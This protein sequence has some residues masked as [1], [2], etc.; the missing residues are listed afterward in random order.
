MLSSLKG[1]CTVYQIVPQAA[2]LNRAVGAS[3]C[4]L[5][6]DGEVFQG[7][8]S[9]ERVECCHMVRR[10]STG[11]AQAMRAEVA[12]CTAAYRQKARVTKNSWNCVEAIVG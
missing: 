11:R 7:G 5:R 9:A 12:I 10:I 8:G 6:L 3:G 4:T 1:W 2:A